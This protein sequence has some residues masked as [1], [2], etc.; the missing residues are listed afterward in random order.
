MA[1]R[2]C[3]GSTGRREILVRLLRNLKRIYVSRKEHGRAMEMVERLRM[4]LP[5]DAAELRDR[6]KLR[7]ALGHSEEGAR[8]LHEYLQREPGAHDDAEVRLLLRNLRRR[9]AL[10]N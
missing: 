9:Q 5:D 2:S 4:L 6:G 10:V 3:L 1:G 8:D 7:L